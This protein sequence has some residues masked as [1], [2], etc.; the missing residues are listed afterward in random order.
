MN[1]AGGDFSVE[2]IAERLD[3]IACDCGRGTHPPVSH[4][5]RYFAEGPASIRALAAALKAVDPQLKIDGGELIRGTEIVAEVEIVNA[6]SDLFVEELS[7]HVADI[8]RIKSP[9]STNVLGRLRGT[10]AIITVR[11]E[12]ATSWDLLAP[13]WSALP[14]IATGLTK[15]DGQGVYDGSTL[16][17]ALS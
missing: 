11:V 10:Q 14:T 13:I 2:T 3:V 12:L 6:G 8:E 1:G 15:V 9:A 7:S 4:Y 17:L 16:V 5:V